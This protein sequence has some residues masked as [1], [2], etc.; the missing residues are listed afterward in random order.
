MLWHGSPPDWPQAADQGGLAQ[1]GKLYSVIMANPPWD[2]RH[3]QRDKGKNRH[4]SRH[5]GTMPTEAIAATDVPAA[6]D[7]VLFLWATVQML[8][9]ALRV[10]TPWGSTSRRMAG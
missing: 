1:A 8:E 10:M 9:A 3:L 2:G 4:A 5:Y 7:S 6:L